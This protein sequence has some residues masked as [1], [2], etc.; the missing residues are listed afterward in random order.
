VSERFPSVREPEDADRAVG[1]LYERAAEQLWSGAR[2][3]LLAEVRRRGLL[4]R[5]RRRRWRLGWAVWA[6]FSPRTL[7][8]TLRVA[9]RAR[10]ILAGLQLRG[11]GPVEWCFG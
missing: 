5:V 4:V 6:R 8:W 11:N 1:A 9:I 10:D 7:R 2:P 3:E